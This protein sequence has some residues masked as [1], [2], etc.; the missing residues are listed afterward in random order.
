MHIK[1][2]EVESYVINR[3]FASQHYEL[4]RQAVIEFCMRT[5]KDV[6]INRKQVNVTNLWDSRGQLTRGVLPGTNTTNI[7]FLGV[8]DYGD[9]AM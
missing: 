9:I 7:K 8:T 2:Q 3:P 1:L 6:L 5:V 4:F